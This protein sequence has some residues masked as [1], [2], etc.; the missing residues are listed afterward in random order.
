[1]Q[2]TKNTAVFSEHCS[3]LEALFHFLSDLVSNLKKNAQ[4]RGDHWRAEGS[5]SSSQSKNQLVEMGKA[6]KHI[7]IHPVLIH[8]LDVFNEHVVPS[9]SESGSQ[10]IG[11]VS[12]AVSALEGITA[13]L[14]AV[15]PAQTQTSSTSSSST[16]SSS[17][18]LASASSSSSSS[19]LSSTLSLLAAR[20][21]S[22]APISSSTSP[23]S[24]PIL[25]HPPIFQ[26]DISNM[27]VMQGG[28]DFGSEMFQWEEG[29][30][31]SDFVVSPLWCS[32]FRSLS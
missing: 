6:L 29:W 22:L 26:S 13:L 18:S 25:S 4:S 12:R 5:S 10:V 11:A 23:P 16:P 15:V 24:S 2:K 32:A 9:S 17:S 30:S 21:S 7:Q 28:V 31:R 3:I 20:A 14:S 19:S 8:F 27:S 1:M